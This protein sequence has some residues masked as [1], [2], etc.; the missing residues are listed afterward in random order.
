MH[1]VTHAQLPREP[2]VENH[3]KGPAPLPQPR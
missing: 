2:A 3:R 1:P